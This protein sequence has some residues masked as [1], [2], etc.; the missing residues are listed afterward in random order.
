M[1]SWSGLHIKAR[2]PK[3]SEASATMLRVKAEARDGVAQPQ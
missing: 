1:L 2:F 3:A